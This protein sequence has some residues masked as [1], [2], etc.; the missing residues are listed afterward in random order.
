MEGGA[1]YFNGE[2]P[3][4]VEIDGEVNGESFRIE[5]N[6]VGNSEKGLQ[7]GKFVCVSGKLPL[8]WAALA[9]T[10]GY[11]VKVFVKY[12]NGMTNFFQACMP[13]GYTQ[14]RT[15]AFDGDGTLT[16]HQEL[17]MSNDTVMNKA[18]VVGRN[19][20]EDSIVIK[21]GINMFLPT[22]ENTF[23]FENGIK[24]ISNHIYPEKEG[25]GFVIA[26]QVTV[27]KP[28]GDKRVPQPNYHVKETHLQQLEDSSDESDHVIQQDIS[29]AKDLRFF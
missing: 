24:C 15:H 1:A 6:G 4:H 16:I 25:D 26:H 29:Y 23:P 18:K 3:Y 20:K 7:K 9:T 10:I 14:D 21:R 28:L 22:V 2:V 12:P 19:F 13:E 8:S 5:G 17:T 11:G 27:N